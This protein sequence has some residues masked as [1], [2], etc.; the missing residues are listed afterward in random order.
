M[1]KIFNKRR[2]F[3]ILIFIFIFFL[4]Y[5]HSFSNKNG[6]TELQNEVYGIH[7]CVFFDE[8]L[9]NYGIDFAENNNE[10]LNENI[11]AVI[12]PH[13]LLASNVIA[14]TLKKSLKPNINKVI[15]IGADHYE[16][17]FSHI[18]TSN[19]IWE[20]PFTDIYPDQKI[21]NEIGKKE[22]IKNEPMFLDR[23]HSVGG[24][25]PFIANYSSKIEVVPLIISS[26]VTEDEMNDLASYF[27][28]IN[29]ANTLFIVSVDFSHYLNGN[30][31][32]EN[33]SISYEIIKNRDYNKLLKLNDDFADSPKS[34]FILLKT[35]DLLNINNMKV[36][37]NFNSG[38]VLNK[39]NIKTTSYFGIVFY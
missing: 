8:Q 16:K 6:E 23:E 28:K 32:K 29:D 4:I 7:K 25:I 10:I 2:I 30:K 33:D 15:L 18:T 9:F 5:N 3:F 31:A 13:H 39:Q 14:D 1:I 26:K 21:I 38:E 22:Y 27:S 11:K 12:I 34:L 24:I 20:T 36:L 37:Q 35:L 19:Y 17:S